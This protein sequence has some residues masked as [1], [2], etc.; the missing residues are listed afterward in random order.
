[1]VMIS[2]LLFIKKILLVIMFVFS[3]NYNFLYDI[4]CMILLLIMFGLF[5]DKE[6][7]LLEF[8]LE[9]VLRVSNTWLKNEENKGAVT[10]SQTE[11][12]LVFTCKKRRRRLL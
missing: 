6:R 8:C 9:K 1:M 2:L 5:I 10:F 7:M 4:C 12:D 3:K 11:I